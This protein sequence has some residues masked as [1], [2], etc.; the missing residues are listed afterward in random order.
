MTWAQASATNRPGGVASG[1]SP[2]LGA[3]LPL[4]LGRL[5]RSGE[6]KW[7]SSPDER[8]DRDH[9]EPLLQDPRCVTDTRV[10]RGPRPGVW[11]W[12]TSR[13]AA[14]VAGISRPSWL[15]PA[16][17]P[18]NSQQSLNLKPPSLLH[19]KTVPAATPAGHP[20][21]AL[22]LSGPDPLGPTPSPSPALGS[23]ILLVPPGAH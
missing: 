13:V 16:L 8:M 22:S 1:P 19:T 21:P 6:G 9:T 14:L 11:G 5:A 3:S 17:N 2:P 12:P 15:C 4:R 20:C 18:C 10:C 7:A 23:E